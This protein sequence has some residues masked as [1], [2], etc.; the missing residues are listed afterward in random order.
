MRNFQRSVT[1]AE[2][3]MVVVLIGILTTMGLVNYRKAVV[4]AKE[5][6][7]KSLLLLIKHAEEVRKAEANT[8]VTCASTSTCNTNLFLNLPNPAGATWSYAVTSGNTS[9]CFC[10]QAVPT[11]SGLQTFNIRNGWEQANTTACGC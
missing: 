3:I 8:Y 11:G 5:K 7:A 6:E 4:N 2:M 10:A 1:L 9:S